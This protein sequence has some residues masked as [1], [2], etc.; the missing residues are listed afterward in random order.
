MSTLK[1]GIIGCGDVT[2]VKSGPGFSKAPGSALVAVMRRDASKAEDYARRHGVP[3]W[4]TDADALINDPEVEAVYIA[5]PPL[6]HE[7]YTVA[8]LKA[9]KPVYVEKPMTMNSFSAIR[10]AEAEKEFQTKLTVAHYRRGLPLFI[11]IKELIDTNEIGDIRFVSLQMLQ[12]HQSELITKTEDNWRVNPKLSGG[13]L[14]HDLAPH[15]IDLMLYFFGKV[16]KTEGISGNQGAYYPADDI[17]TGQLLFENGVIFKGIWCFTVPKEETKDL[18]EIIGSEGKITFSV[19]GQYYSVAKA[20]KEERYEV[21][22]PQ[23]IQQPMIELVVDYFTG[24]GENPCPA[25][26]GIEVMRIM[27]SFCQRE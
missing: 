27:D 8:A 19:F 13:G 23:H 24:K 11:K 17:V 2:E 4:Y 14:F 10:M 26:E 1:W 9:G 5:T 7:E 25:Q 15:Q 22:A 12:P 3:K 18:V 20:G 16:K 6:F 21:K